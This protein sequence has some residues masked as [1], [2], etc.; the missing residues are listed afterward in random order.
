[1]TDTEH[2]TSSGSNEE[3]EISRRLWKRSD[4]WTSRG[5]LSR[6]F[7]PPFGKGAKTAPPD[8]AG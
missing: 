3:D 5:N 2:S 4:G 6:Y 7:D 1:M 8:E